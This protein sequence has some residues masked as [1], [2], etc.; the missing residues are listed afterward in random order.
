M[1]K[2]K[3]LVYKLLFNCLVFVVKGLYIIALI[4]LCR[5]IFLKVFK[6]FSCI[7]ITML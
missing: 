2:H 3:L 7:F 1:T 5:E 4:L 6:G